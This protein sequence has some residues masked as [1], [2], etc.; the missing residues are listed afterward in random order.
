M[1][2]QEFIQSGMLDLYAAGALTPP[3]Q[4]EVERM[5][6]QYPEVREELA[7]ITADLEKYAR[8]HAVKPRP[9]LKEEILRNILGEESPEEV[10][11][12]KGWCALPQGFL[13]P[14]C[15]VRSPL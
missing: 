1:T 10:A 8:L 11:D 13:R 2:S 5:A 6:A 9:E 4:E 15:S 7:L 12:T 3:E 14:G